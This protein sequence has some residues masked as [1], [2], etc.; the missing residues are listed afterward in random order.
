MSLRNQSGLRSRK[1]SG[2]GTKRTG[3]ILAPQ[4]K[5][6]KVL[7]PSSSEPQVS[8]YDDYQRQ[9]CRCELELTASRAKT[10]ALRFRALELESSL[11]RYANLFEEAPVGLL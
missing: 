2:R 1:K 7:A 3:L 11:S 4:S 8:L 9:L 5:V 10:D 6:D